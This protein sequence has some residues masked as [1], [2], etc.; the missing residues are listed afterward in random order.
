VPI[1]GH[2]DRRLSNGGER[3]VLKDKNGEAILSVE[4]DDEN[5]WPL[6]PDGRGDSLVL[7]RVDGD[8]NEASSWRAS[9]NINGSPGVDNLVIE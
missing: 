2:Y 3:L 1:N 4:Y 7:V 5:G 6:S 8:P 9:A